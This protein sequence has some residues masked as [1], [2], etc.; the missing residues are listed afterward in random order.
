MEQVTFFICDQ[1][2]TMSGQAKLGAVAYRVITMFLQRK[3]NGKCQ[4]TCLRCNSSWDDGNSNL[5]TLN[6]I[7]MTNEETVPPKSISVSQYESYP[8]EYGW[9]I[10]YK[11]MVDSKAAWLLKSLHQ[12]GW[13]KWIPGIA[14][15]ACRQLG[16]GEGVWGAFS[17]WPLF[18]TPREEPLWIL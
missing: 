3:D 5:L 17:S 11:R 6:S 1:P 13:Q 12:H 4:Q 7:S 14:C 2:I 18:Y 15:T 9:C 16:Q 10:T 8:L